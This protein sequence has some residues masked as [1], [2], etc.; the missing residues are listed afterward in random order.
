MNKTSRNY[1]IDLLRIISMLGVV[2]LHLWGHGGIKSSIESVS[3]FR[4]V[5]SLFTLAGPA[6]DCFVLISGFVGYREDKCCPRLKNIVSLYF[7]ALFYS[8]AIAVAF[9]AFSPYTV[10]LTGLIKACAIPVAKQYWFFTAYFGLVLVSPLLNVAVQ[11][12]TK[13]QLFI[14]SA[15]FTLLVCLSMVADP[16]SFE[17]GFSLIWFILLYVIGAIIKKYDLAS[18]FSKK[19]WLLIILA[20]LLITML[21]KIA[22]DFVNV[23]ALSSRSGFLSSYTSP[24]YVL[25]AIGWLCIFSKINCKKALCP[26]INFFATSAFSVYL[27]HD[28]IYVRNHLISNISK[29]TDGYNTVVLALFV[30]G[31]AAAIFL[32][33]I[34]IDKVRILLFRVLRIDKLS[35]CIERLAKTVLNRLFNKINS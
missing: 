22:F 34:L 8:A 23:P 21:P 1:G 29:L 35:E 30:F 10:G 4:I 13:K 33:C 25:M 5:E 26:A 31:C 27:I 18:A 17:S 15:A 3:G 14:F 12:A 6:V 24:T 19:A 16:F 20:S 2:L 32:S 28:N 11:K 9:M 7:T